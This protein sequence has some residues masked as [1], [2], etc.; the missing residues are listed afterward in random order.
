MSIEIEFKS[1]KLKQLCESDKK[2]TAQFGAVNA[3]KIVQRLNQIEA[4]DSLG[5]LVQCR[6]GRCHP[7]K[8]NRQG[9]FAL[10]VEQ[11]LRLIIEPILECGANWEDWPNIRKIRVVEVTDYHE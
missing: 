1:A 6:I 5:M 7:L 11:P 9:Q 10:D 4:G 8:G 2:L 3:R